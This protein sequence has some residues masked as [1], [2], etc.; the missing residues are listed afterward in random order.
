MG[1]GSDTQIRIQEEQNDDRECK[2]EELL[3]SE[4]LS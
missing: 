1:S 4:E 3:G 2:S